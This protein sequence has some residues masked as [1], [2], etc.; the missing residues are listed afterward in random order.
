MTKEKV[1]RERFDPENIPIVGSLGILA[2]GD[3]GFEAWRKVRE[4]HQSEKV[5]EK[6]NNEEK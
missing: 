6:K 5:A 2:I 4:K 1:K 3:V